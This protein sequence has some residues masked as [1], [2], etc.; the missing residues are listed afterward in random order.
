ME[1]GNQENDR[2]NFISTNVSTPTT[3]ENI[4]QIHLRTGQNK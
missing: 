2:Y 3:A 4:G 1:V